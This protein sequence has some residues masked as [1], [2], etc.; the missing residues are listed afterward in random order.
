MQAEFS[1]LFINYIDTERL[2]L[3]TTLPGSERKSEWLNKVDRIHSLGAVN[4]ENRFLSKVMKL[5]VLFLQNRAELT[6]CNVICQAWWI[7]IAFKKSCTSALNQQSSSYLIGQYSTKLMS[8]GSNNVCFH[9]ACV[10]QN[11]VCCTPAL[12]WLTNPSLL[13]DTMS[14]LLV[15]P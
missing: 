5:L 6:N 1:L 14:I 9:A 2:H 15:P 8:I 10:W 13:D 12:I 3:Q 4:L 11:K 7:M